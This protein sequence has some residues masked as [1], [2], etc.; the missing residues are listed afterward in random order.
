M[1]WIFCLIAIASASAFAE[2]IDDFFNQHPNL[3]DNFIV[4]RE[5]INRA[6]S[7]A[8]MDAALA[9]KDANY[10]DELMKEQGQHYGEISLRQIASDCRLSFSDNEQ[11]I[12]G[13]KKSECN[14]VISENGKI[15]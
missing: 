1:K 3:S 12:S 7:N 2:N 11:S 15:N 8:A 9:G 5:I 6:I 4:K 10:G 13:L 14:L